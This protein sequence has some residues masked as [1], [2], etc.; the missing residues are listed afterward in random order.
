M[1]D[2]RKPCSVEVLEVFRKN[3]ELCGVEW[4]FL[5]D[6]MVQY[7]DCLAFRGIKKDSL[8]S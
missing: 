2:K 4:L 8:S 6:E 7:F 5:D 1:V 3:G